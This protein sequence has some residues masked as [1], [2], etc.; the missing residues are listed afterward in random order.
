MNTLHFLATV[1]LQGVTGDDRA[2]LQLLIKLVLFGAPALAVKNVTDWLIGQLNDR[3]GKDPVSPRTQRWLAYGVSF[4]LPTVLYLI[5]TFGF[6]FEAYAV[7]THIMAVLA[8]FG[9]S[10]FMHGITD[11]PSG[12]QV[13]AEAVAAKGTVVAPLD[14]TV[15]VAPAASVIRVGGAALSPTPPPPPAPDAAP[16]GQA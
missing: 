9:V 2:A 6:K 5:Y 13:K 12:D 15:Y 1:A 16:E 7:E 10:Q 8:A 14:G 3:P 11:L 4:V